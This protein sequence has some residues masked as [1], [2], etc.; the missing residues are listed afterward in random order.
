MAGKPSLKA[1]AAGPP[2]VSLAI[3]TIWLSIALGAASLARRLADVLNAD[4][5]QFS[6]CA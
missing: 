2:A 4:A 1:L 3:M 6:G 5:G